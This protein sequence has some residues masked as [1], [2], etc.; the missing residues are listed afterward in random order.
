MEQT[1]RS[2]KRSD[3]GTG[4]DLIPILD[5]NVFRKEKEK[6]IS[7]MK[8]VAKSQNMP[9]QINAYKTTIDDQILKVK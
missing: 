5:E 7:F 4:R 9:N 8:I 6:S 1:R 2:Q 3:A